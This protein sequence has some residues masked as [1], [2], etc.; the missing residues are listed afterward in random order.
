M[1]QSHPPADRGSPSNRNQTTASGALCGRSLGDPRPDNGLLPRE[2]VPGQGRPRPP[3]H[4]RRHLTSHICSWKNRRSFSISSA[5]SAP[6]ISVRIMPCSLACSFFSFSILVLEVKK[7]RADQTPQHG[8]PG[9]MALQ[10][11]CHPACD[12]NAHRAF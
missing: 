10:W 6:L 9:W 12:T 3:H 1:H 5:I 4:P 7:A 11:S 2:G 8:A